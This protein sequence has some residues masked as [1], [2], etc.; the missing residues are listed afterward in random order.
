MRGGASRTG[1]MGKMEVRE[2]KGKTYCAGCR[3]PPA[4]EMQASL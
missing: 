2:E 1:Q 3:S 4:M